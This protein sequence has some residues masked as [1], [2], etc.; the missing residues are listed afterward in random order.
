[1]FKILI[2]TGSVLL[3][4]ILLIVGAPV[5]IPLLWIGVKITCVASAVGFLLAVCKG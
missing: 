3:G 4:L 2:P 5:V 1:M